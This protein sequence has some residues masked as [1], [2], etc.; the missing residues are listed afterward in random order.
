MSKP[1]MSTGDITFSVRSKE[2]RVKPQS[3]DMP[4]HILIMGNFSGGASSSFKPIEVDR[5]NFEE[6]FEDLNVKLSLPFSD[7]EIR[8]SE[9]DDLHPDYIYERIELFDELRTLKR[10]LNKPEL[11]H[12]AAQEIRS[13][14]AYTPPIN[15]AGE[16]TA[17]PVELEQGDILNQILSDPV[18]VQNQ[19]SEAGSIDALIKQ[20]VS[21][22]VCE[23]EDPEL[24][25]MLA[26]VDQANAELM[27]QVL[28]QSAFQ[29]LEASWRSLYFLMR[30][31][32]T[33]R[34]LKLFI[35]DVSKESLGE[36]FGSIDSL[37]Q[38]D[39]FKLIN[40]KSETPGD[41]PYSLLVADYAFDTNVDDI[42]LLSCVTKIAASCGCAISSS[43]SEK[44]AGCENI[45]KFQDTD[46][47][48]FEV[49]QE[50]LNT[51]S[52]LRSEA[53]SSFLSLTCPR[54]LLRMPYGKRSSPIESFEFE[55][56]GE[57][58]NHD[59]YCW[60]NGAYMS[61]LLLGQSYTQFGWQFKPGYVQQSPSLP[62]HVV[63][64]DGEEQITPA[65]EVYMT[66]SCA[67]RLA[68][69][70]LMSL[71][72]VKNKDHI[73]VSK[74]RSVSESGVWQGKWQE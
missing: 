46:D 73:I 6:V 7:T 58:V 1:T 13:W 51:W 22:Y 15:Q 50:V 70:G 17:A 27:R 61:A 16:E 37:E 53:E 9:F 18:S 43:M 62:L 2:S 8:F 19:A 64:V 52:S 35:L 14:D 48:V 10:K 4:M 72:S 29:K 24:K 56:L 5:D 3:N 45:Q 68:E 69:F 55:E 11:F 36:S 66:D 41:V 54:F 67:N 25:P 31:L 40:Q 65:A 20:I 33:G 12:K 42:N 74:F 32:E 44:L 21:P 26:A 23:K 59:N 49:D 39:L 63:K 47:W 38:S 57:P 30:H 71:R 34:K 28:H 60:G